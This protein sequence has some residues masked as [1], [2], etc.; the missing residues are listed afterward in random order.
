[1]LINTLTIKLDTYLIFDLIRELIILSI[2]AAFCCTIYYHYQCLL[3]FFVAMRLSRAT[4]ATAVGEILRYFFGIVIVFNSDEDDAD[5]NI[6]DVIT[7]LFSSR[8]LFSLLV[9][10]LF[11]I[12][13]PHS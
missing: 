11:C 1:M 9:S 13:I 10:C 6:D 8:F 4:L 12:L 3:F 7:F 2:L 5:D